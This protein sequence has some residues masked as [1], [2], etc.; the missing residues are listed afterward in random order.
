MTDALEVLGFP[1]AVTLDRVIAVAR[2]EFQ[3][4]L[5]D[6]GNRRV[7]PFRFEEAGYVPV[8]N[9]DAKDGLWKIGSRR[10]V[11][12][13]HQTLPLRDQLVAAEHL[14]Q[15]SENRRSQ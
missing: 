1:H 15:V 6:R 4:Y 14:H 3:E 13:A 8:R 11:V 5:R 9:P 2:S 12:Y 10:I 7:I